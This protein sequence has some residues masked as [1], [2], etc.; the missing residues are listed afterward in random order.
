[1][2]P[3][4]VTTLSQDAISSNVP[5]LASN[6]SVEILFKVDDGAF[7]SFILGAATTETVAFGGRSDG[8]GLF[9]DFFSYLLLRISDG[10]DTLIV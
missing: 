4:G 2:D 7:M 3:L 10:N 8:C 5:L 9:Q 6:T 1:M